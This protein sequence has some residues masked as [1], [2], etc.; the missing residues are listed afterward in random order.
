MSN[1][2]HNT[3]RTTSTDE[4]TITLSDINNKLDTNKEWMEDKFSGI[5]QHLERISHRVTVI[6]D[7]QKE[8]AK[9]LTYYGQEID[10]IKKEI[11]DLK[12]QYS[13]M[14]PA[15]SSFSKLSK[16]IKL[17]EQEKRNKTLILDGIPVTNKENLY[18]IIEKLSDKLQIKYAEEDIDSIF[19]TK[20]T[21]DNPKRAIIVRFNKM[22]ARDGLYDGRKVM[23]KN[24]ITTK[25]LGYENSDK[26]FINEQLPK[27]TQELFY[28]VRCKKRDLNYKYA[29]TYH[30]NIFMRKDKSSDAIR[31][32][33][34]R[35]LV[36]LN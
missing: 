36:D 32:S 19:R 23:V 30:G 13:E 27:E 9:A 29:W 26:I 20:Q 34:I 17:I 33:S 7:E 22:S 25:S 3:R 4:D 12:N 21:G 16:S 31:I 28:K 6:E 10:S 8:Q 2:R 15:T 18:S 14:Q 5:S 24:S 35:D 11:S 1:K